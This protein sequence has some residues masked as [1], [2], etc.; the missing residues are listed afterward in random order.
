MGDIGKPVRI[1]EFE[2]FPET[3][4]VEEPAA[5]SVPREPVAPSEPEKAP[6]EPAPVEE[7]AEAPDREPV[8]V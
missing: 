3:A 1:V 5:P 2:P 8:P 4:P 7:P 6:A